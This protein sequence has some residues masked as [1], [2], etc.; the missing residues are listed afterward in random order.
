MPQ[1]AH[2]HYEGSSIE[3]ATDARVCCD[4]ERSSG[5]FNL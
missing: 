4:N 1:A 2:A 3:R 5:G